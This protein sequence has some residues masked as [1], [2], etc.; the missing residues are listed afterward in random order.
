MLL[1][2]TDSG[3]EIVLNWN[4]WDW[5]LWK[6]IQLLNKWKCQI[7]VRQCSWTCTRGSKNVS[8][9][10]NSQR[11][12]EIKTGEDFRRSFQ[13]WNPWKASRLDGEQQ[14]HTLFLSA[15]GWTSAE[16]AILYC[17]IRLLSFLRRILPETTGSN[18]RSLSEHSHMFWKHRCSH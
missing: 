13:E 16:D 12:E 11:G 18:I 15:A 2:F 17:C 5:L 14:I 3:A 4:F 1:S 7:D 10:F 8:Q 6:M 9:R